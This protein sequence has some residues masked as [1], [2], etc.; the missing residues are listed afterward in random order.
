LFECKDNDNKGICTVS[1]SVKCFLDHCLS[2]WPFS[3][4][5]CAV[6][7]SWIYGFSLLFW[8][9]Q[10]RLIIH[11]LNYYI[12]PRYSLCG[13]LYVLSDCNSIRVHR[14]QNQNRLDRRLFLPL[15][16]QIGSET[17]QK[18]VQVHFIFSYN[19]DILSIYHGSVII[20]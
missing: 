2:F 4:G 13:T 10:T 12:Q 6:C 1:S 11:F 14:G 19:V 7:P 15:F 5:H 17:G 8:Y 20:K 9:L 18:F 3:F 16:R